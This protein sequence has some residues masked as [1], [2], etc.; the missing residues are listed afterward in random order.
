VGYL[1]MSDHETTELDLFRL[2]LD[3]VGGT[4]C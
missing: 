4:R 2:Y 1:Q 3:E